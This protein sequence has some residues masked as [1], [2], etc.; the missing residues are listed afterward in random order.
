[1]LTV[2]GS[3][4][5]IAGMA[6]VFY[7]Q[8]DMTVSA[9]F[10]LGIGLSLFAMLSWSLGTIFLARNK[11]DMNPYYAMGWQMM[12][13][14]FILLL[15]SFSIEQPVP[16][17]SIAIGTWIKIFYLIIFGSIL[18]F[19]AFIYSN[20]V[21]SPSVASLYAYANP[22]VAMVFAFFVINEPLTMQLIWGAVITLCGVFLVNKGLKQ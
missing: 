17:S 18:T 4:L 8:A 1:M 19:I 2:L 6:F 21:L 11:F 22:F 7:E 10:Y 5:G 14:S 20:K 3:L 16:I 12:I 9:D 15:M 13:G